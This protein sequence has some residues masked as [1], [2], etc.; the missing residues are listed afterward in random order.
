MPTPQE[1]IDFSTELTDIVKSI[2]A[3]VGK[4]ALPYDAPTQNL[5]NAAFVL[6]SQANFIGQVGLAALADDVKGAIEQL[7]SEVAM[8][9]TRL[10]HIQDVKKALNIVGVVLA[11]AANIAASA[12]SGNYI[13]AAADVVTLA[14]N[15]KQA[16]AAT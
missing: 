1:M 5:S 12:A 2:N 6:A 14:L 9:N 7:K 8:A 15:V 4:K 16:V 3:I 13:G 11:S 10:Q